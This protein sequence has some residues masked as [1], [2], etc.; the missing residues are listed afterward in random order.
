MRAAPSRSSYDAVVV[1]AGVIGLACAWRIAERGL[2]VC[3]LERDVPGAGASGVAA[4]MLAPATEAEFGAQQLLALNLKSA[5]A[6][7]AF[8]AALHERAGAEVGY[9]RD[10]ALVV[11]ADRDDAE[12]LRRLYAFQESL[13]LDV[14]WLG[15]RAAR[16]LE[17][18]LSPRIAGAIHAPHEAQADPRLLTAAL[19]TAL[20]RAGGELVTGA[21]VTSVAA[22]GVDTAAAGPIGAAHVVVAAGCWSGEL[23]GDGAPPVRPVKGQ[24]LRLRRRGDQP[25]LVTRLVR[26]PR[27]YVVDRPGG[28]VVIGATV[29]ERGFDAAVTADGVYRL[30][31]A[32]WEVLPDA[33]ELEWVEAAARLRPGTPDNAPVIGCDDRGVIW[34]TGHYRNGILLAPVTADAVAAMAAGETPPAAVGPFAPGRFGVAPG[35]LA[36]SGA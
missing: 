34:A 23:G 28:E 25:P 31:E 20:T 17:P 13:G 32:A 35:K 30:L 3:V 4:G 36:R 33:G 29:E 22:D 11:A 19:A 1:G 9:R 6:W 18:G 8:A 24:I 16:A 2:S 14:E 21:D 5:A 26:T 10:G 15:S 12:E 27:C 7:P